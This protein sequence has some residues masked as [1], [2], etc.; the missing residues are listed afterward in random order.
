MTTLNLT[1]EQAE[2]LRDTLESYLSDLRMENADTENHDFREALKAKE[3]TL[4]QILEMLA[5]D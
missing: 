2:T 5:S 4:K 1:S 3:D